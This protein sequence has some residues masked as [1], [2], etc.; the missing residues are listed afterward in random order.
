MPLI[1]RGK[2]KKKIL[3]KF[4]FSVIV[5]KENVF[6]HCAYDFGFFFPLDKLCNTI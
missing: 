3:K 6:I 5:S 4:L 2:R 1:K